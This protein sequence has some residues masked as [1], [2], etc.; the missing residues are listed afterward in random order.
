MKLL[1]QMILSLNNIGANLSFP[2]NRTHCH[3]IRSSTVQY[4]VKV[5]LLNV[6]LYLSS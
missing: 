5:K 6:F 2:Y 3:N 4:V 1:G